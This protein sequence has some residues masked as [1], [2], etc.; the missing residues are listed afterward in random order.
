MD[1]GH[2]ATVDLALDLEDSM[3]ELEFLRLGFEEVGVGIFKG[4]HNFK[5]WNTELVD[6][7][8]YNLPPLEVTVKM[9]VS[10][11]SI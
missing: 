5:L 6:T 1:D 7:L 10:V 2:L 8:C 3:G 9:V 11:M 4:I